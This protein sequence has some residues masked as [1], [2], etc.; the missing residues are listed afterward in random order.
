MSNTAATQRWT[1][2]IMCYNE[3]G[4]IGR[5]LEMV[6]RTANELGPDTEVLAV[7]DGSSDNT[8]ELLEA[9][10]AES[11][12]NLRIVKHG[13]NRGIGGALR[14]IYTE[15]TGDVVVAVP[16]DGQFN[17]DELLAYPVLPMRTV[18]S[19]YR[20]ENTSYNFFRNGLSWMNKTLNRI[21]LGMELQDVNWILVFRRA[22]LGDLDLQMKSSIITSEIC[23]KLRIKG[24]RFIEIK[25]RYLPRTAGKSRGASL[26]IV[27]KAASELLT[28][29]AVVTRFRW[30]MR[31]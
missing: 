29:F 18:F 30:R 2:G 9:A 14:S 13:Q 12:P 10:K 20:V 27:F 5:V 17:T 7:D 26:R 6:Q 11:Y 19:Y 22:D 1:I 28:L 3:S 25:S 31:K 23:S 4:S 24:W 21:L 8:A 16:G 15:A